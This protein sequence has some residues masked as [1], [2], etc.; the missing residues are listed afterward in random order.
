VRSVN[1]GGDDP[2]TGDFSRER[3]IVPVY[4]LTS[5]DPDGIM[6]AIAHRDGTVILYL[7]C[8][9]SRTRVLLDVCRAAQ[10]STGIWEAAGAAQQRTGHLCNDQSSLPQPP[11]GSGGLPDAW[12]SHP[13]QSAPL[14]NRSSRHR[15]RLS[16][17]NQCAAMDATRTIGL[18]IQR[19]HKARN[20]SLRV[21]S[22]LAGMSAST[23]HRIEHG[24]RELT[25]S[26]IVA[27]ASAL[28]ITSAKLIRLPILA[29]THK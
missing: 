26:E 17:A 4:S 6:Q 11:N 29:P 16:P 7:T 3:W 13:H 27:L 23:L 28:E 18:H 20:K 5:G 8:E 2:V 24:Q 19:I 25:L 10:L 9:D 12:R 21:I 15:R 1:K 14:G 22:G